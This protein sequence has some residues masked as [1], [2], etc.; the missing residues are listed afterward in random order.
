MIVNMV[1][2][3]IWFYLYRDHV[4]SLNSPS[5]LLWWCLQWQNIYFKG[6]GSRILNFKDRGSATDYHILGILNSWSHHQ[7]FILDL[8]FIQSS[9]ML[10]PSDTL[11]ILDEGFSLCVSLFLLFSP[12]LV[13][14]K[15]D[16]LGL[17]LNLLSF[18]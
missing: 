2:S 16:S 12:Q 17:Y 7:L 11:C 14:N 10:I 1:F 5:R 4:C 6:I 15:F 18:Y 13:R 3:K 9:F 8:I